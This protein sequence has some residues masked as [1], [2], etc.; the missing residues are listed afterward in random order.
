MSHR[1]ATLA[2]SDAPLEDLGEALLVQLVVNDNE[3]LS[4]A[5]EPLG[6]CSVDF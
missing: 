3:G 1:T 2:R 5:L 4:T 6:L